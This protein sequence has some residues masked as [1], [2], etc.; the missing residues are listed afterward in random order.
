MLAEHDGRLLLGRQPQYPAG[1]YSA[2]AGF[3]EPGESIEAAVARELQEEAGIAR[4]RRHLHRQPALAV[5]FV[6][7]DRLPRPF[8]W[9]R[10]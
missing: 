8:A 1:R 4:R 7:D 9:R 10:S 6:A 5:P 2:L 3:L